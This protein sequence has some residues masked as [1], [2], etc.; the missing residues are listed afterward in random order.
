MSHTL[1]QSK[2]LHLI[3]V[4]V[5]GYVHRVSINWWNSVAAGTILGDLRSL[6]FGAF[7]VELWCRKL[8]G[9]CTKLCLSH[10]NFGFRH[11]FTHFPVTPYPF[12][13]IPG[14]DLMQ[15][16]WGSCIIPVPLIHL[17]IFNCIYLVT[18][19]FQKPRAQTSNSGR[20]TP[21]NRKKPWLGSMISL[22]LMTGRV[23]E[24]ERRAGQKKAILLSS[25]KWYIL[26]N[27]ANLKSC[28]N[29]LLKTP[30]I[31]PYIQT[32]NEFL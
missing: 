7:L 3:V 13:R 18:G 32:A 1:S 15:S 26:E 14:Q 4:I 17:T 29:N 16:C 10:Q 9:Q 19:P 22:L 2:A 12:T 24:E 6:T 28:S 11:H 25:P 5:P 21:F 8:E 20:K 27:K 31:K 23:R 30:F